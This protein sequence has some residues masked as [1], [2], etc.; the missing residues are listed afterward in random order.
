MAM[1][2]RSREK[3]GGADKDYGG[4]HFARDFFTHLFGLLNT[5]RVF[6]ALG[7]LLVMIVGLVVW[8]LPDSELAPLI[9][10]LI[11]W[12]GGSSGFAWVLVMITNLFWVILFA[13]QK[14]LYRQEIKRLAAL[15]SELMHGDNL[16]LIK[17][18]RSS[19]GEQHESYFLPRIHGVDQEEP[20]S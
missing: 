8:R 17:K 4:W 3:P 15:R 18:H 7:L 10:D 13:E 11:A 9:R 1:D 19:D 14:K 16:T 6:P 5:G 12:L 2:D 20:K